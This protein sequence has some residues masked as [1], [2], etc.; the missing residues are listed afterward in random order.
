MPHPDQ[1]STPETPTAIVEQPANTD[2]PQSAE[3]ASTTVAHG[4]QADTTLLPGAIELP[5]PQQL[6]SEPLEEV[7]AS[8]GGGQPTQ[9]QDDF[10]QKG[11]PSAGEYGGQQQQ[12]QAELE[13]GQ[14]WHGEPNLTTEKEQTEQQQDQSQ[15][16]LEENCAW[17]PEL[18]GAADE[19]HAVP[20]KAA[21]A[22]GGEQQQLQ[23][24]PEGGRVWDGESDVTAVEDHTEQQQSQL[25]SDLEENCAWIPELSGAADEGH[26]V[27]SEAAPAV[28][29]Q[30]WE[31]GLE[32]DEEEAST[33]PALPQMPHLQPPKLGGQ[34][35]QQTQSHAACVSEPSCCQ[36]AYVAMPDRAEKYLNTPLQKPWGSVPPQQHL[37]TAS[38]WARCCPQP[39]PCSTPSS[40]AAGARLCLF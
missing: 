26:A 10:S 39:R 23:A 30:G 7:S 18:S 36:P 34:H 12:P 40:R 25:Q 17:V 8:T 13:S 38:E 9:P 28:A 1:L 15:P 35:H 5:E 4:S 19:Q 20:S 24:E 3:S 29:G 2:L 22:V 6:L 31:S 32:T 14:V 33:G 27:L 16:D 11:L 37:S 21:T